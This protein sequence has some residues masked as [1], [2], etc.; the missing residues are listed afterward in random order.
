MVVRCVAAGGRL[1]RPWHAH[2]RAAGKKSRAGAR[3]GRRV[4]FTPA[5]GGAAAVAERRPG[6]KDCRRQE[7]RAGEHVHEEEE[8]R[9]EVRGTCLEFSRIAG[10]SR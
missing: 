6:A 3:G 10:T 1:G 7:S 5:G 8:E 4:G 9:E 2:E